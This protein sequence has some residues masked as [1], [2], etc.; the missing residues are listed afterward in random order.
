MSAKRKKTP[1]KLQTDTMSLCPSAEQSLVLERLDYREDSGSTNSQSERNSSSFAGFNRCDQEKDSQNE[2]DVVSSSEQKISEKKLGENFSLVA[3]TSPPPPLELDASFT[4]W[5]LKTDAIDL[6]GPKYGYEDDVLQ[7]IRTMI[8]SA[9]TLAEKEQALNEMISQLNQLKENLDLQNTTMAKDAILEKSAGDDA[10]SGVFCG[11]PAVHHR[12]SSLNHSV[13]QHSA[14]D[15]PLNLSRPKL[16]LNGANVSTDTNDHR[17]SNRVTSLGQQHRPKHPRQKPPPAHGNQLPAESA[18]ALYPSQYEFAT[19]NASGRLCQQKD[20]S[21]TFNSEGNSTD[22]TCEE[23]LAYESPHS[24][25]HVISLDSPEHGVDLSLHSSS[26]DF[27]KTMPSRNLLPAHTLP[28]NGLDPNLV[29]PGLSLPMLATLPGTARSVVTTGLLLPDL[30]AS[31]HCSTDV[32]FTAYRNDILSQKIQYDR[33][34]DSEL[35]TRKV[36]D[37]MQKTHVK[38]PMNAFMVWA[39]E[40]RRKILKACPDMHNSSISKL[41]GSKWKTMSSADKQPFYEEQSRLS[42]LHM[43]THPDYRYRPRPKR[44]C[45]MDGKK[46]RVSEYKQLMKERRRDAEHRWYKAGGTASAVEGEQLNDHLPPMSNS[47][48]PC[49]RNFNT[50]ISTG[51][52]PVQL[53]PIVDSSSV[54]NHF[55]KNRATSNDQ[56]PLALDMLTKSSELNRSVPLSSCKSSVRQDVG[57]DRRRNTASTEVS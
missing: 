1:I 36:S 5:C 7:S 19:V 51:V 24:I 10:G 20:E 21:C 31:K 40:E 15:G 32:G 2:P 42:R 35:R 11:C 47:L 44:T 39:R 49:L 52:S 29:Y 30:V 54:V 14:G 55:H 28:V 41:L 33:R 12:S 34:F 48:S 22:S 53:L 38:R 26:K 46:L 18:I 6:I 13:S 37:D 27:V 4:G 17:F 16:Q 56:S 23:I 50:T 9:K 8:A 57:H 25:K 45:V 3:A 43:E